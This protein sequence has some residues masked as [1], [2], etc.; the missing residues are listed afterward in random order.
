M[1][2]MSGFSD[3][4]MQWTIREPLM[5]RVAAAACCTSPSG[6]D[7]A[8]PAVPA[9]DFRPCNVRFHAGE[10][11]SRFWFSSMPPLML[12]A[13]KLYAPIHAVPLLLFRFKQVVADPMH[14]A[15]EAA[16]ATAMSAAFLTM[17]GNSVKG[18]ICATR[19]LRRC[20]LCFVCRGGGG[21]VQ[22]HQNI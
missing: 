18:A 6:G 22:L 17:Y 4:G 15:V 5:A 21:A 12:R 2:V 13:V 16:K 3:A 1:Q 8:T 20:V 19:N 9:M 14:F 10:S 11:C 7:S